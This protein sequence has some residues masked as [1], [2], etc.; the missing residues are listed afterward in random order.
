[1]FQFKKIL[2]PTDFSEQF[3]IALNYAKELAQSTGA[4]LHILHVIEHT[5]YPADM[6]IAQASFIDLEMELNNNSLNQMELLKTELVKENINV[7][8]ALK[9]GRPSDQIIEYAFAE[10]VDLIC[11]ATHGRSGFE[12]LL[13]G[14]TTEKVLRKAPCPV[15]AVRIPSNR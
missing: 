4:E 15:L 11:I 6:G 10:Q 5:V 2:V 14:S 12:H 8:I 1:M 9:S 7:A 3:G 13:F